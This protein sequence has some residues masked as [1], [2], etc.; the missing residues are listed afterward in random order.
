MRPGRG[1]IQ[2]GVAG[3]S[4]LGQVKPRD[5]D[6]YGLPAGG[7]DPTKTITLAD[8]LLPP[9]VQEPTALLKA[10]SN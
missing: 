7:S 6:S 3:R 4:S 5:V 1:E 2:G 8:L 9:S 10:N